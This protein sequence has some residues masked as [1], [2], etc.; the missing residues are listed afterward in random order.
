MSALEVRSRQSAIQ[1]YIYLYRLPTSRL[2][3]RTI[4]GRG[5][6]EPGVD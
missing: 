5:K 1:I 6:H 2:F 4:S 3:V